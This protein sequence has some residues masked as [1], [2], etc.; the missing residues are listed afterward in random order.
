MGRTRQG[1]PAGKVKIRI[2]NIKNR[3]AQ[4]RRCDEAS[5][6]VRPI[7]VDF[8]CQRGLCLLCK[9]RRS[10]K[11]ERRLDRNNALHITSLLS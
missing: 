1:S 11:N 10:Q 8:G 6:V 4:Q 5:S 7:G 3:R 9:R 2:D